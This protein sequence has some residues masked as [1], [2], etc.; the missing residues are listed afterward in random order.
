MGKKAKVDPFIGHELLHTSM[1]I[2]E[3]FTAFIV[4]HEGPEKLGL[5]RKARKI[6]DLLYEFYQEVGKKTMGESNNG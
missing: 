5:V 3:M 2:S 4:D 1:I 6:Q